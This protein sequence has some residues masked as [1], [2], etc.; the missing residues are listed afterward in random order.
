M[1]AMSMSRNHPRLGLSLRSPTDLSFRTP[2]KKM[3]QRYASITQRISKPDL[4][5]AT[6]R[7]HR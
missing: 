6:R 7:G 4:D 2:Q 3:A 5:L 1:R